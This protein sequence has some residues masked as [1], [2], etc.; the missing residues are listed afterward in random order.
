MP[1]PDLSWEL[2]DA[3]FPGKR[4]WIIPEAGEEFDDNKAAFFA[5][6]GDG[7]LRIPETT[8]ASG[9]LLRD[10][11]LERNEALFRAGVPKACFEVYWKEALDQNESM[12][13]HI[14]KP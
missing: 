11:W 7:V 3:W 2:V 14:S 4:T 5:S 8:G 13:G 12:G 9:R 1:R 10:A 6:Q